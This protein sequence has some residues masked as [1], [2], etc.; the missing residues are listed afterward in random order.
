MEI[1][2]RSGCGR[3][4]HVSDDL[5]EMHLDGAR[6]T[7]NAEVDDCLKKRRLRYER[8][9]DHLMRDAGT[10][11]D[12]GDGGS[13]PSALLERSLGRHQDALTVPLSRG[14]AGGRV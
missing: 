7:A 6:V 12:E 4:L 5:P 10:L 2:H 3:G 11:C 9:L 1:E 14:L 8:P 13:L